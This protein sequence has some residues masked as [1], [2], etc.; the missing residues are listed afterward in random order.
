MDETHEVRHDGIT[1]AVFTGPRSHNEAFAWLLRHQPHSVH[2]AT[3]F[4]GYSIV[5][6]RASGD[7]VLPV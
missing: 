1:L 3:S 4:E 7:A 2:Y 5:E 6:V